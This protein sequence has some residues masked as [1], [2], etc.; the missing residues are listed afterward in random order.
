MILPIRRL[1]ERATRWL[2]R[3]GTQPLD[4][5][6]TV[7]ANASGATRLAALLP[8]LLSA[9]DR[10]K[11]DGLAAGW[12]D[13]G[14]GKDLAARVAALD[15]LAPA[16]DVLVPSAG[17][18][19]RGRRARHR[20]GGAGSTTCSATSPPSTSP[21]AP[22]SSSTGSGTGSPPCPATTAGRHW[23]APPSA[24]T[25]P[26]SGPPSPPR[27]SRGGGRWSLWMAMHRPAVDR[28]L[29]VVDDIRSGAPPDLATLS[30]A[31]REA[32]RPQHGLKPTL[33]P[34][35]KGTPRPE[36]AGGTSP[37]GSTRLVSAPFSDAWR[38]HRAPGS[39][40]LAPADNR[41]A[42][43]GRHRSRRDG[44]RHGGRR[45]GRAD[46][47]GDPE[48]RVLDVR[49]RRRDLLLRRRRLPGAGRQPGQRHRRDG[50]HPVGQRLLD[51]RRRRRRVRRR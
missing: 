29:L 9:A 45:I 21:S 8:T 43:G 22:A 40:S 3:H 46:G 17:L 36:A 42:G 5:A 44:L 19:D 14:A 28:F 11:A 37:F 25:T 12:V 1:A 35:P 7:A 51:G 23:P 47:G 48:R 32:Q 18:G 39:T 24:T 6:A 2:V 4:V 30:V 49:R 33:R 27:P 20:A 26:G 31:M 50:R 10:E 16:L 15:G 38:N 34:S 13:A 41:R